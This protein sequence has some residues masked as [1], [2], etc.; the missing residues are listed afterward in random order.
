ML[1][2][3]GLLFLSVAFGVSAQAETTEELWGRVGKL[4]PQSEE[5]LDADLRQA[6]NILPKEDRIKR[7]EYG[8]L[9]EDERID[10]LKALSKEQSR[11]YSELEVNGAV[12]SAISNELD[13]LVAE[14]TEEMSAGDES[15][16][17][18]DA[19]M[20]KARALNREADRIFAE[21]YSIHEKYERLEAERCFL[22]GR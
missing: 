11:I 13:R 12:I 19:R 6:C 5:Q 16:S 1:C 10:R 18:W 8:T 20:E 4:Q 9:T 15:K 17:A 14:A 21:N 22:S 3:V 2:L 7:E